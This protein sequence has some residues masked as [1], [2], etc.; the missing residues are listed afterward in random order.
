[1]SQFIDWF[2][3]TLF[4]LMRV[5]VLASRVFLLHQT[6]LYFHFNKDNFIYLQFV[7]DWVCPPWP[8]LVLAAL[9]RCLFPR[10]PVEPL[11]L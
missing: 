8:N 6:C 11:S 4:T 7:E 2:R 5:P 1:M 9:C 3:M 10:L